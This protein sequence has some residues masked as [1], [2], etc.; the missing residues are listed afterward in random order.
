MARAAC[1][2]L[3]GGG[4]PGQLFGG[5]GGYGAGGRGGVSAENTAKNKK[6]VF[7]KT[8]LIVNVKALITIKPEKNPLIS[9]MCLCYAPWAICKFRHNGCFSVRKIVRSCSQ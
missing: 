3:T 6:A 1:A 8:L 7:T 5:G 9:T 2:D 4:P